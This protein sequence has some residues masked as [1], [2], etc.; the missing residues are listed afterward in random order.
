M[1]PFDLTTAEHNLT[2]KLKE[3]NEKKVK[4]KEDR[5]KKIK[6]PLLKE[7]SNKEMNKLF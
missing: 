4:F 3:M 1:P 2:K 5:V 7:N 6:K